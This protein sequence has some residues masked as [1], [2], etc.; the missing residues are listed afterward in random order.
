MVI[1]Y[2]MSEE[3]MGEEATTGGDPESGGG[4]RRRMAWVAQAWAKFRGC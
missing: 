4:H 2:E 1:T 3:D